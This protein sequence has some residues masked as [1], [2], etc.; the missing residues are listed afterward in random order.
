MARIN[1]TAM[2][3]SSALLLAIACSQAAEEKAVSP[4]PAIRANADGTPAA[5]KPGSPP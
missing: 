5:R 2:I 3:L 1:P 4:A